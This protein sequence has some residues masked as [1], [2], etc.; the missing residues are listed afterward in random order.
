MKYNLDNIVIVGGGT[1]GWLSALYLNSKFKNSK[2][3]LIESDEIGILGAGEGTTGN[4]VKF[5]NEL[6]ITSDDM[7]KNCEATFKTGIDFENWTEPNLAYHHPIDYKVKGQGYAYHFNARLLAKYLKSL[8]IE[9]GVNWIE[10]IVTETVASDENRIIGLKTTDSTIDASFVID[11]SGFKRLL[12]GNHYKSNWI[13]YESHLKVNTAIPFFLPNKITDIKTTTKSIAMKHGWMWQI[14]L[15]TR[16]G[17]GYIFDSTEITEDD[18]KKEII[19]WVGHSVEFNRQIKFKPG[20]YEN[21]WI[22]NC[23]AIGLSTGFLEPLE[24]TSIMTV[25]L[26][27]EVFNEVISKKI[28]LEKYNKFVNSIN[29]QNMIFIY[30]HY[31]TNRTD[32]NFWKKVNDLAGDLPHP[33]DL[34]IDSSYNFKPKKDLADIFADEAS[35]TFGKFSYDIINKGIKQKQKSLI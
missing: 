18:A 16:M 15:Q 23:L 31:L 3:T 20:S 22:E 27:L 8:S 1:A 12:I 34:I 19:E 17:C 25:I 14:P 13:S 35:I 10:G 29:T 6:G 30:Y 4:I 9:R 32:T 21:V 26:Q 2:I 7:I 33:L 24:A 28:T 11:C 5:L